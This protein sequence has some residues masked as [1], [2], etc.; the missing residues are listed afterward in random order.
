MWLAALTTLA[1]A[2]PV[3][4]RGQIA[5]E[6]RVFTSPPPEVAQ[7]PGA[8]VSAL[9]DPEF[10]VDEGDHHG[11]LEPFLRMDSHDRNRTHAD[12]RQ[13]AYVYQ[14][15]GFGMGAGVGRFTWGKLAGARLVDNINQLDLVEDLLGTQKLGQPFAEI[16]VAGGPLHL[17]A[18]ALPLHRGRT[19]PGLTGRIRPL[20]SVDTATP[21]Y[22]TDLQ[23]W[24]P[25][26]AARLSL[27]AGPVELAAS[28][29]S[30]VAREPTFLAQLTDPRVAVAY[31]LLDQ[32]SMDAAVVLGP[33]VLKGEGAL[34]QYTAEHL[35]SWAAGGGFEV[36]GYGL[37]GAVDVTLLS[38]YA[39]DVRPVGT[40]I[41]VYDN[42]VFTGLRV[43]ANDLSGTELLAGAFV[44]VRSGFALG[45]LEAQ[46]RL[47]DHFKVAVQGTLFLGPSSV[48]EW[49]L[50]GEDHVQ[51]SFQYHL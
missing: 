31:D 37:I 51:L 20:Y 22:E 32:G 1:L 17:T 42:D 2:G 18:L 23:R 33:I 29:F 26:F 41:T 24:Q 19:F 45:R 15:G 44:D 38:E 50:L 9:L 30:G 21:R 5:A 10:Q 47:D 43:A 34:R 4:Y 14:H 28:G 11:T 48:Q 46:R 49:W 39:R 27:S 16:S 13:A 8:S 6:A 25:S 3:T 7:F 12:I 40:P 35:G 36:T